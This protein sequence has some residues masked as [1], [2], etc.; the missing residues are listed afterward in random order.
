[1]SVPLRRFPG[2][3]A[4][5]IAT[6]PFP[7]PLAPDV[8]VIQE[9]PLVAVQEHPA[10]LETEIVAVPPDGATVSDVGLTEYEQAT[11]ACVTANVWPAIVAVP[12]RADPMFAEMFATTVPLPVRLAPAG[13]T[14]Q[15]ALLV[16]VHAQ[17]LAADTEI[18]GLLPDASTDWLVGLIEYEHATAAC[19]TVSVW[20]AIAS[21]PVRAGPAF[22]ATLAFTDPAPLPLAPA[23]MAIHEALLV[24]DHAQLPEADTET[25]MAPPAAPTDWLVGPIEYEQA[26]A[27]WVTV[28]VWPA[29]VSVPVRAVPVFAATF[30]ATAPL[31]LPLAPAAIETK[32]ALLVA[33]QPQAPAADTETVAVPPDASS[34]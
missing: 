5:A 12:V 6:A 9:S 22:A 24:A 16:A 15:D 3:E 2:F 17:P 7:V 32:G 8:I 1:V 10:A 23:V 25:S 29:T 18:E 13:I 30:A 34:D 19:V 26:A 33:V 28:N 31:P 20:P 27:A 11:A 14:I 21:V 4:T